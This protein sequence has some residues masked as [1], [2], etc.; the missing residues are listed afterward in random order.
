MGAS[1]M[2]TYRLL[3]PLRRSAAPYVAAI[4]TWVI[5]ALLVLVALLPRV[6]SLNDFYTTDE[7]YFWQQR[8]ARFSAALQMQDWAATNQT[9][10]PGV[11]TMWLGALGRWA[12]ELANAPDPAPGAGAT[13]LAYLRLPLAIVNALAVG[14]GYILLVHLVRPATALLAGILWALAPFLIAHSRLLHLDALLTSLTTLSLLFLLVATRSAAAKPV[15]WPALCGSAVCAGLALLTKAPALILL[16]LTALV[17]LDAAW[18][19]TPSAGVLFSRTRLST[20]VR[21]SSMPFGLWLAIVIC[22]VV[23][24]W[25]A[26][27]VDPVGAI[28]GAIG[29]ISGNAAQPHNAGNFFRGQ[30]VAD[31]G[32]TFYLAVLRYRIEPATFIGLSALLV[33]SLHRATRRHVL[34][35]PAAR[36]LTPGQAEERRVLLV[37]AVFIGLFTLCI[38][39][40][41]KKFDR[42]LL[43]TW[44][45]L[46]ILAA[47]GLVACYDWWLH[48]ADQRAR[49]AQIFFGGMA[50]TWLGF[51]LVALPG[52]YAPYYLAYYNPLLGGGVAAQNVLLVGW[53]EGMDQ[54]GRWLSARP[55]LARGPVLSWLPN[56]LA[57]FIPADIAVYDLDYEHLQE[58]ASY[59][60]IYTS[61]AVRD[62]QSGAEALAQQSPPLATIRIRGI[63]YATIHQVPRPFTHA[64]G[65]VFGGLHLRG[66]T[67]QVT[68]NTLTL[69][70][71]WDVRED[72]LA[73][74]YTFIHILDAR[75]RRIAQFDTPLDDGLYQTWQSGQQ[76][77]TPLPISLPS[78]I[79]A[80]RYRV[81][82]GAYTPATGERLPLVHGQALAAAINGPHTIE[83]FALEYNGSTWQVVLE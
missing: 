6:V 28:G 37:L 49:W 58:P 20:I 2:M 12:A 50:A 67:T 34:R 29:E 47:F 51:I 71:S 80:G 18:R 53:G 31:P 76:F 30:P 24:L 44:P 62:T 42:Y 39:L 75:G 77:G 23:M 70:P 79:P 68:E 17:L 33:I 32:A 57:P 36:T 83:L 74:V 1:A 55:D 48:T 45:A 10:H 5:A 78:D 54:V 66:F 64:V 38:S 9:G 8:V 60:V 56:T 16:P 46:Q 4:P 7:A 21:R 82:L 63:T 25:P 26:L 41:A 11:T 13:Y 65:A 61:V 69:T 15:T 59:A 81:T 19:A 43:P 73:D 35:A 14:L 3:V 72:R 27:W 52:V 22:T 40:L